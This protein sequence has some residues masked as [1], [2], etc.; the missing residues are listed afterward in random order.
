MTMTM[1]T[2]TTTKKTTTRLS[3]VDYP[4]SRRIGWVTTRTVKVFD[5]S[6][7]FQSF[8][9]SARASFLYYC[10]LAVSGV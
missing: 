8:L 4:A 1:T 7:V 10:S 5:A 6:A 3:Q 9:T 2:K